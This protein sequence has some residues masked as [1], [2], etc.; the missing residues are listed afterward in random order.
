MAKRYIIS[1]KQTQKNQ[2]MKRYLLHS[3]VCMVWLATPAAAQD[4]KGTTM[5]KRAREMHRVLSLD[6]R[7]QWKKFIQ[8]NYSKA[9]IEKPMRAEISGGPQGTKKTETKPADA[10]EAKVKMFEQLH[11]DFG[12]SK[13][14]SLK[15]IG[16]KVE[17][18][19]KSENGLNGT[20][21][22]KFSPT[23]PYLI[24]GLGIEVN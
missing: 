17:M 13:I 15:A 19:L 4:S 12:N 23:T 21:S 3:L 16:E 10:L 18:V 11:S 5:E 14:T 6:D 9:L 7:E 24:D 8:E 20:F 2:N 22:L 1:L